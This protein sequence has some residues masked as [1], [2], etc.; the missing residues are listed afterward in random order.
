MMDTHDVPDLSKK[1]M[2]QYSV[3][4]IGTG[5][6]YAFNNAVLPLLIPSTNVLLVNLMSNTR[7]IE[8]TVIQ[9]VVGAWSDR[10]WTRLGRRRPFMLVAMPLSALFMAITPLAP[11]LAG[12]VAC[13]VAF[14][15]LF[16]VAADPYAALMADISRPEQRPTL[17]AVA[18]V[19]QFV[20]QVGLTLVLAFGPFGKVIPALAYPLVAAG[21]LITSLIT[22][23]TV[24]ERRESAHIE[25]RRRLGEYVAALQSHRQAMRY[26]VA[27]FF[28]NTGI[29]TIQVNLTR[30]A[31]HVLHVSDSDALK[32]FLIVILITGLLT[33]PAAWVAER[34]GVKP[35]IIAGMLL[36]AV[37]ASSA[38]VV[39]TIAQVIPVL[40]V[41]GIGNACLSLAWPLLTLLV[42]P[43]RIG[44]FAGLKTS[45]ESLSAFFSSF[46]AAAMVDA[47][48]Y[49][50]I[51]TVLLV[52]IVASLV[53][54]LPIRVTDQ[55]APVVSSA[56]G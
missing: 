12:I 31:I 43:E 48:G 55:P 47:W 38:F 21:I 17:N 23:A 25:P 42:P 50:S 32:L 51:F 19:V 2:A 5:F 4:S 56:P 24:R 8:G 18:I 14:S 39:T 46:V 54:L 11:N 9:P 27:L 35:V 20:G 40:V 37:A 16:N 22:V 15:L 36:I 49:R 52:A 34:V 1:T 7:S 30:F 10:I 26:L 45:A 3:A 29:N 28:Y 41:A 6:F 33:V 53:T 13:I 44:V